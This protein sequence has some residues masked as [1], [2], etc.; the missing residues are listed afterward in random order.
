MSNKFIPKV[1]QPVDDSG[2]TWEWVEMTP[3]A[4]GSVLGMVF[5]SDLGANPELTDEP[6]IFN[7]KEYGSGFSITEEEYH[8]PS[9]TAVSPVGV[10]NAIWSMALSKEDE[11]EPYILKAPGIKFP[12]G[13]I[14]SSFDQLG[15]NLRDS[16]TVGVKEETITENEKNIKVKK[17]FVKEDSI[18]ADHI[19]DDTGVI[20]VNVGNPNERDDIEP[21]YKYYIQV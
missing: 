1:Y 3:P 4:T 15:G 13:Q 20:M 21:S 6:N 14:L 16:E 19:S 11:N 18:T 10:K 5:I 12:D 9:Y 17:L 8:N 7:T 2:D